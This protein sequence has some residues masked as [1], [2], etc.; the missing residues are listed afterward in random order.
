MICPKCKAKV[1]PNDTNCPNCNLKLIFKCPRCGSPSRLGSTSCKKC[2]FT[3]VKFC[4]QCHSANYATSSLCRKCGYQ[5]ENSTDIEALENQAINR[6]TPPIKKINIEETQPTRHNVKTKKQE[7]NL[8]IYVDFTNIEDIFE[9]YNTEEFKQKVVQNIKTTI[10]IAFGAVCEFITPRLVMFP[11]NYKKPVKILDKLNKFEQECDKFNQILEKT[12]NCGV[13]YKFVISTK[14]EFDKL[15]E[16]PQLKLG[17]DKD[18]VVSNGAYLILNNELSLI[19]IAPDSYKMIFL[20]QKPV[21]EETQDVKYEKAS[22]IILENLADNN[23]QIRAISI[24]APRGAGKTHLLNDLY[25]KINRMKTDN[26]IVFYACC[27]ALTQVS[28]YGLI[29]SFFIS[30]FDCPVILKEEFNIKNFEKKVLE[31]LNLERIDEDNLETLANL[32]YPI[33]RDYFENILINKEIT[34]RYL[35]E[36]FNYIKQHKNVIFMIDDFDLI[37]ESSFGF[38]KY[39]VD[40]NYFEHNAKMILGYKNR[41]SV[42]IYFQSSK[43]TSANCLNI[44]L[45]SLNGSECKSFTRNSLGL[46]ADVPDEI[47]SQIAYNAQG[48]IAYIEQILQYLYERKILYIKDKTVT[49]KKDNVDIE[50]PATLE[51]CFYLRLDFLKEQNQKEYVFLMASSL[52]GNRIDYNVLTSVFN[53]SENEFF[54]IVKSL[55]KKGYLK[56][57]VDDIYGFKNSLTWSYCYIRAKEEELIKLDAKKMLVELNNKITSTPLICPILAQIIDNKELAFSLWTKNLQYANYIGDLNIYAMAQKQSLILLE[58]V[59]LE[60]FDYTK[61][62]ICERLGKLIYIK[63]PSEA[64][65]YLTNAIV[66]AQKNEDVNKIID[67]SGYLVKSLYLTQDF[68]GVVEVVDNVL[69]Y[70]DIKDKSEKRSTI[71]LQIA[72]IKARKLEAL[73]QLG[74]WEAI[75]S[76]VN[77]EINPALQKHLNIFVKHKWIKQSEIFYTWIEVNIILAQSYCEQGSP[78]A[79]ELINEINKVLSREKGAKIDSLKVRLAYASAIANT[80]RGYFVESDNILQEII[81]DYSYVIDNPTLVC[82]WNI[83]SIIN[84]ILR[85]DIDSIKDDLFEATAYANN[86]G[87][88][89]SKNLLKTLLGYV[90]LEEKAYLK[91]IEIATEEM[92]YFSSKKIAFGALLA[93]YIS[94]AATANNKADMYCIEICEK[95]VKICENAQNNNFY[96]KIMFQELLAKSYLKLNDK[97]NAQMYCD[98]ALQSANANELLYL[99]VRLNRLKSNIAREKLSSQADNKKF[100]FAQNTIK[101]YNRTIEMAK[102]LNLNNMTKKI[103]K[104]LTSFRA[105]CQLNRIIEDK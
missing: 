21:F 51:E 92:Q 48:N 16:V 99:Q 100:E 30:L 29:Q 84:K 69:K 80:S 86:A 4:P 55:D 61:N 65:D 41:H 53:L 46:D 66:S 10:K 97:E 5:F 62:N 32:I 64:K 81:K 26:T 18:V 52:L 67:L 56:R 20:D 34:Y 49:F 19:K 12:L 98:L 82:K 35:S 43:L 76:I 39:L 105:H 47:L 94:A 22:Q 31:K 3:F 87:D 28:P 45:R 13:L 8:L 36:V 96:F 42:A 40:E 103:E 102:L 25:Y 57:K 91:A 74:S 85:L 72:L 11:F 24:N 14:E 60:N 23:S 54:D 6:N 63:S 27:S 93:W 59:Q 83:I 15:K 75:S 1:S 50:L 88:E 44:S 33:K 95:A 70:F 77:T 89:L 2:G 38:L 17:S 37:D 68:T 104:E 9:K 71:E 79:F 101:M 78:L 90:F 7:S 73:L 58:N